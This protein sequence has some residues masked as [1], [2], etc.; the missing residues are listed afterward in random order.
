[1]LHSELTESEILTNPLWSTVNE[2]EI[3]AATEIKIGTVIDTKT[4]SETVTIGNVTGVGI[5]KIV[6]TVNVIGTG[7]AVGIRTI[8]TV[9]GSVAGVKGHSLP[10][11]QDPA[12]LAPARRTGTG[13]GL[14]LVLPRT[15]H[16]AAAI[17]LLPQIMLGS[18]IAGI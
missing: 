10:T 17:V 3:E 13:R 6:T 5:E 2:T 12:A 7:N 8:V 18:V 16:L 1:M 4:G 11:A 15:G 14:F 9:K